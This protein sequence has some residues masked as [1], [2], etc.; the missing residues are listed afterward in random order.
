MIYEIAKE[1]H[2]EL[3]AKKVPFR[4]VYGPERKDDVGLTDT[5][6]VLE[7]DRQTGDQP[8]PPRS[9]HKNPSL[10]GVRGVGVVLRI[11]ARANVSGANVWDHERLADAIVDKAWVALRKIATRRR[12]IWNITSAK[13]LS[14]EELE[15]R[16]LEQWPGAV[17]EM[18]FTVDRGVLDTD[19]QGEAAPEKALG[20]H[21]DGIEIAGSTKV[22]VNGSGSPE[23]ACGGE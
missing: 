6:I 20:P 15:Q 1:L 14:R 18:R 9:Q 8:G 16:S 10:A 21:P 19:W 23:T 22:T 4:V 17:Y 3:R 13:L 2:V 7:R 12:T 11:F 5:R